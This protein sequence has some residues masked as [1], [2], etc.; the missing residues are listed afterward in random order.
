MLCARARVLIERLIPGSLQRLQ[1]C[2]CDECIRVKPIAI[3][4]ALSYGAVLRNRLVSI[5]GSLG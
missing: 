4:Q 3:R 2:N 1:N 5:Y